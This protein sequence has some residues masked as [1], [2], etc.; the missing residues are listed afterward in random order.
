LAFLLCGS[1]K[2]GGVVRPADLLNFGI[3]WTRIDGYE[4]VELGRLQQMKSDKFAAEVHEFVEKTGPA[5]QR[6][7]REVNLT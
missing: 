1:V 4:L 3:L 2:P 5:G 7:T 6:E